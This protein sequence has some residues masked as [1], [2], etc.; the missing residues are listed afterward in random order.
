MNPTFPSPV[1]DKVRADTVE[2]CL[3]V[4][5]E[6]SLIFGLSGECMWRCVRAK[7]RQVH[8]TPAERVA[9]TQAEIEN[10]YDRLGNKPVHPTY[11]ESKVHK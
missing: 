9:L 10:L 1:L 4:V 6:E 8:F 11:N 5:Y 7:L 2:E 3:R